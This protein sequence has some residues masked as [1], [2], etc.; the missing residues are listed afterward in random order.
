MRGLFLT[1]GVW[2]LAAGALSQEAEEPALPPVAPEAEAELPAEAAP[3]PPTAVEAKPARRTFHL[4]TRELEPTLTEGL[5][6]G[7]SRT[8]SVDEVRGEREVVSLVTRSITLQLLLS[9]DGLFQVLKL[10]GQE[11]GRVSFELVAGEK[12]LS[13]NIVAGKGA[14][15][16]RCWPVAG[17]TA[18]AGESVLSVKIE[19][20]SW[21]FALLAEDVGPEGLEITAEGLMS[22]LHDG[23]RIDSRRDE[24]DRIVFVV[25]GS[26]WPTEYAPWEMARIKWEDGPR[27]ADEPRQ[28]TYS[29]LRRWQT[30][31]FPAVELEVL[32]PEDVSP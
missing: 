23:Q 9:S 2:L 19:C 14:G 26:T 10:S 29:P 27:A 22:I 3:P 12:T 28:P 18:A 32:R 6:P 30:L 8:L 31:F 13:W 25:S 21:A 17:F 20:F 1:C 15:R 16:F 11:G 7:E 5:T 4:P 24:Q